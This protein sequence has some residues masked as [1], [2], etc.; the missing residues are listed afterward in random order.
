MSYCL[1]V[2]FGSAVDLAPMFLGCRIFGFSSI[3]NHVYN[4]ASA[5][6]IHA[7]FFTLQPELT[8]AMQFRS[9]PCSDRYNMV[10]HSCMAVGLSARNVLSIAAELYRSVGFR[11]G[12]CL[13]C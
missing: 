1:F 3:T 12:I 2:S 7:S 9:W 4:N 11:H 5:F 10:C 6:N 8:I 13:C